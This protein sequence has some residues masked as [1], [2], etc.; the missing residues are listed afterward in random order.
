MYDINESYN[1]FSLASD[2][3]SFTFILESGTTNIAPFLYGSKLKASTYP[4]E[5][6][7][8]P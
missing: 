5:G 4:V 3:E 6:A 2:I 1:L 7:S 8:A